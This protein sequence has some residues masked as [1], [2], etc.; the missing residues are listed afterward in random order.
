[1]NL[2]RFQF[3][4]YPNYGT[5]TIAG[6][7]FDLM[8]GVLGMAVSPKKSNE[9]NALTGN[10]LSRLGERSLFFHSLASGLE[11]VVPLRIIN[12]A[13]VWEQDAN[14]LPRAFRTIG[15]RG[16]QT[17]G[18][19]LSAFS[20]GKRVEKSA[21]VLILS[22]IAQAMDS[23]GNLFFVTL[24]PL[25]VVCWDSTTPYSTDNIKIVLRNDATLQFA[26]GVKVVKNL[27]G[28]EE[29]WILTNRFQ[30]FTFIA[31]SNLSM[32]FFHPTRLPNSNR[33]SQR[34]Q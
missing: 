21:F 33:K 3:Y 13:S 28:K 6:E 22:T 8:D 10:S 14:S 25:A 31:C 7:S 27:H 11:N 17:A 34:D 15:T 4:P 20:G 30:V 32:I 24:D 18:E 29:L 2:S 1:M 19:F 23:N 5:F 16:I 26:S 9:D 12:N